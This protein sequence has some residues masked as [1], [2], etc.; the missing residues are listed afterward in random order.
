MQPEQEV[1]R[2]GVACVQCKAD[3]FVREC[4]IESGEKI[5]IEISENRLFNCLARVALRIH[6]NGIKGM[7]IR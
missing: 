4:M 3:I 5:D 6:T 7:T 2:H 1:D